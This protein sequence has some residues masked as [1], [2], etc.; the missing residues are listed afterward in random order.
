MSL[1]MVMVH[2]VVATEALSPFAQV[3]GGY[4]RCDSNRIRKIA[5]D[6]G[7]TLARFHPTMVGNLQLKAGLHWS[8]AAEWAAGATAH[9]WSRV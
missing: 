5:A 7:R 1:S 2:V 6:A 4:T 9:G 8:G 3:I